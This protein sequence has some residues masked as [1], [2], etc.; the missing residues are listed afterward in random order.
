MLLDNWMK[1]DFCH[2][3]PQ[4][5]AQ[6]SYSAGQKVELKSSKPGYLAE[7]ISQQDVE[8]VALFILDVYSK[9]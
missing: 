2:D 8:G 7:D 5:L 4:S 9:M 1:G 6:V 3:V